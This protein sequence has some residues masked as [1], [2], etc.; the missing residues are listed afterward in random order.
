M[1]LTF[2]PIINSVC[3]LLVDLFCISSAFDWSSLEI[4]ADLICVKKAVLHIIAPL[5]A[6]SY[7]S[8]DLKTFHHGW[9]VARNIEMYEY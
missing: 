5:S 4:K 9:H 1:Y 3:D 8:Y 7:A 2:L 6:T